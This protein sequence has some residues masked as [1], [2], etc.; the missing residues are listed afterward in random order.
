MYLSYLECMEKHAGSPCEDFVKSAPASDTLT[1]VSTL[2]GGG[3]CPTIYRTD[4]G[5]LVV[6]GSPVDPGEAG[7]ELPAGELLVE[8]PESLL[9]EILAGRRPHS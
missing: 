6:Q 5:T 3:T 8:I 4:R 9:D 2:C 1:V 7:I